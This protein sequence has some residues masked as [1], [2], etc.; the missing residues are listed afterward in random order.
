VSADEIAKAIRRLTIVSAS[1]VLIAGAFAVGMFVWFRPVVVVQSDPITP[2][3]SRFGWA[4]PDAVAADENRAFINACPPFQITGPDGGV[5]AQN[6]ERANVRLWRGLQ[7][8]SSTLP[9]PGPQQIGDCT[10]WGARYAI[11]CTMAAEIDAGEPYEYRDVSTA[12]LYGV[13][14]V[15]ILKG[16]VRGDGATG[17]SV[18]R[19]ARDF[20]VLPADEA[21]P[22]SGS[23]ATEWG[24]RGPPERLKEIAARHRVKT[25]AL[26]RSVSDVR[27]A[28]CNGYGVSIA[29]DWG[30]SN[31]DIR[32]V[33]G[34]MVARHTA[35]WMHQMC[36]CG[37]D[38]SSRTAYFYVMN[39][40][41]E[42]AHPRPIDD[43]PAGGF[44]I[45][46]RDVEYIV[47]FNDSWAF[48]DFDGFP[49]R[50]LNFNI[51][52]ESQKE[53]AP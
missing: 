39:S 9:R 26:M 8:V 28:V 1:T 46:S 10:S 11:L 14:R 45:T 42:S 20:G 5:V 53:P 36:I 18:A 48:S 2:E 31:S 52:G 12:W 49:A 50:D 43:A 34:R 15:W 40:W 47:R 41:G 21:P 4:G 51:F 33:D 24:R 35:R 44:W 38:G 16:A 6:N 23:L 37:Y 13:A 19:A 25:V 27:D 3:A 32:P 17:S 7:R 30:T 22:Y 29:S